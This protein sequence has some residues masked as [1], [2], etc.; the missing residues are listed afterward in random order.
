M[1]YQESFFRNAERFLKNVPLALPY[2]LTVTEVIKSKASLHIYP[3]ILQ[4]EDT[5]L[6]RTNCFA[7]DP[8]MTETT[9]TKALEKLTYVNNP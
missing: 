3:A 4:G 7:S 6:Q 2:D 8:L 1:F 5:K 9:D